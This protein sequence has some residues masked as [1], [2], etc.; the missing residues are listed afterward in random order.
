[1]THFGVEFMPE[2]TNQLEID[3]NDNYEQWDNLRGSVQEEA[4]GLTIAQL[5][6][7]L[8]FIGELD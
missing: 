1:M 6:K 4:E 7:V 8:D 2:N 3:V 5:T